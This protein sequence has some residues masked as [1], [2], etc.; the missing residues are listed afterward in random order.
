MMANELKLKRNMAFNATNGLL[1]IVFPLIS[2]PYISRVLD[3][4][5]LGAYNYSNSIINYLIIF[6]GLGINGY[7][8]RTGSVKRNNS[9]ELS[10]FVSEMFSIS[11]IASA[12]SYFFLFFCIVLFANALSPYRYLLLIQS[13]AILSQAMGVFW[14]FNIFEDFRFVTLKNAVINGISVILMLIL[15]RSS[16]DIYVYAVICSFTS[17]GSSLI[18]FFYARKR[19][20]IHILFA[21]DWKQH[22]KPIIYFWA[23]ALSVTVYVNSDVTILGAISGD[24]YVGLYSVSTK[25]YTVLKNILSAAITVA[26]PRMSL[27]YG[28]HDLKKMNETATEVFGVIISTVLPVMTGIFLF[29]QEIV[30]LVSGKEYLGA[31]NSLVLLGICIICYLFSYFYGQCILVP[32]GK[33]NIVFWST[34][35]SAGINIF[36]NFLLIPYYRQDAAAFTSILGEGVAMIVAMVFA[37]KYVIIANK[38]GVILKTLIGCFGIGIISFFIKNMMAN[39]ILTLLIAALLSSVFYVCIETILKNETIYSITSRLLKK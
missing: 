36:L 30:L 35:A 28:E 10:K 32:V 4:D 26:I 23:T 22:I 25:I 5:A 34:M 6:A 17:L 12:V 2:F 24:Y 18:N 33:E 14:I 39:S 8:I 7:A 38:W 29:S 3:V 31:S 37:R 20:H 19:C 13:V 16:E 1:N 15:I 21:I 11:I 9:S 27:L